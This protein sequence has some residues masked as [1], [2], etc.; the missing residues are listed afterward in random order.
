[1]KVLVVNTVSFRF[2]GV[3][4][5]IMNYY[6]NM[7][8]T[9]LSVDFVANRVIIEQFEN[10]LV[11][12]GARVFKTFRDKNPLKYMRAIYKILKNGKY[13][14]LHV[15]G[16]SAMMIFD[17]LPAVFAGTK[18][19]I[20]HSHNTTCTHMKAH[21]LL[22]P[23]FSKC[24]THAFACGEDAGKWLF[25]NK[26]FEVLNNGINLE[27]YAFNAQV[28]KDYRQ[29][30]NVTNEKV[31]GHVGNFIE[32]KN[33][34]F[35][36]E[37][38]ARLL[39]KEPSSVLV[40]FGDGDNL[41]EVQNKIAELKIEE[42]VR[43]MGKS[44]EIA[45]YMQAMDVF[46][47]PSLYEGLPVVLVEAQSAGLPCIVADTVAREANLSEE[48]TYIPIDSADKW[49]DEIVKAIGFSDDERKSKCQEWQQKIAEK[50]Y[51]IKKNANRMKELYI[52]YLNR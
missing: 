3:T 43:F 18:V 26:K 8:K 21:K 46:V 47:L 17:T 45:Q 14:V 25:G 33:H 29:K 51:D 37:S 36:L 13:D 20:V 1:M 34:P 9:D 39:E 28:R 22:K 50:G 31:I 44:N 32:Q 40:L 41:N 49:V 2:N 24:Y 6:R 38:F 16:N 5:V 4:S 7:D 23:F 42:N 15:H 11:E 48:M 52:S 12:S 35:L 30:L 27:N 19:R 10:E